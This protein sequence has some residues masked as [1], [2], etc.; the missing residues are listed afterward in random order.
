[1]EKGSRL[2]SRQQHILRD[3][4]KEFIRTGKA[5]GSNRLATL[6]KERLSSATIRNVVAD[7]EERGFVSQPHTSAGRLPTAKG[8]SLFVNS[9]IR[10]RHLSGI[11]VDWIRNSLTAEAN[12]GSM[13]NRAC[14]I[15]SSLSDHVGIVVAPTMSLEALKRIEF[16]RL[17]RGRV[18][19]I[20]VSTDGMVQKSLVSPQEDFSQSQLDDAAGYLSSQY[21]GQTLAEIRHSLIQR[22]SEDKALYD[23]ML[24]RIIALGSASLAQS[25][26]EITDES[27]VYLGG[28]TSVIEH[29]G[30]FDLD[31]LTALFQ[32]FERKSR[33]VKIVNACINDE[34][35]GTRV[36]IG[37]ED[38]FPGGRDFSLISSS[39]HCGS[40]R[41]TLGVLGPR[42]MEY[43]RTI[44]V[45]D[46]VAALC[47]E[48]MGTTDGHGIDRP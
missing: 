27:D 11:D 43:A 1:M 40:L 22:L 42:R 14:Q 17:S 7:L 45:V 30:E 10:L 33:L 21:S 6:N 28:T 20:L 47:G 16:V 12:P 39:Y 44:S 31:Q 18:V 38:H 3:L 2:T 26:D 35:S 24:R 34:D 32:A 8:Y 13:M 29:P 9:L 5:V 23:S 48:L 19:V 36:T 37:L 46:C 15:L 41:G 4:I 25:P